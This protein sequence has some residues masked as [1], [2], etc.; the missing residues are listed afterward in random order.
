MKRLWKFLLVGPLIGFVCSI[1]A[2]SGELLATPYIL[3]VLVMFYVAG[4]LPAL[5]TC[6]VDHWLS[7]KLGDFKRA[8]AT[9]VAGYISV[10]ALLAI[11]F[12]RVDWGIAAVGVA[13]A[14]AGLIC[15]LMSSEKNGRAQ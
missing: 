1:F 13:G 6:A 7:D 2:G 5:L 8:A 4:A 3:L 10:V 11:Y 12:Q 15:S 14:I 9:S